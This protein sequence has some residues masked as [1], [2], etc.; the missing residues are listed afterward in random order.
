NF[1]SRQLYGDLETDLQTKIEDGLNAP[2]PKA[3]EIA[4]LAE[5]LLAKYDEAIRLVTAGPPLS[6]LFDDVAAIRIV[7]SDLRRV[8]P[9][10]KAGDVNGAKAR[11]Q[12]FAQNWPSVQPL[13]RARSTE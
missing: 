2:Q 4:P 6:P 3:S 7:R 1:R 5:R 8:P 11:F 9:L 12:G 10:L 13:F